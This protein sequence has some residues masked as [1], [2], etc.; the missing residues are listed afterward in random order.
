MA[1]APAAPGE[2][3]AY[4]KAKASDAI[5]NAAVFRAGLRDMARAEADAQA[6]LEVWPDGPDA[7]RL[8]LSLADLYA[9]RGQPQKELAQL[10]EYQ[11]RYAKEPDDWLAVQDR[12]ARIHE[13][14]GNGPQA[15]RLYD[16]GL[17][18]YRQH[19]AQVKDRGLALAAQAEYLA[20]EP[21]FAAYDKITLDV[22]PRYLK[23]QL[24]VKAR[25]LAQ[26]EADYGKVVKMKQAEPAICAL[27]RIGLGYSHFAVA[28]YRNPI[29]KEVKA[30][31]KGA[32]E[33]Y[34]A[35]L[36][37]VGEPLEKKAAEGYQLAVDAS[38]DYGVSNAC[39]K[40]AAAAL[41]KARPDEAAPTAAAAAQEVL[42]PLAALQASDPPVGY[43]LLGGVQ[44]Q[45]APRPAAARPE[46]VLPTLR[47][48]PAAKGT[49]K[50]SAAINDPQRRALDPD[51][52]V[53]SRKKKGTDDE[54]LLP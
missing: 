17:D 6:Y 27:H 1:P 18:Y 52:P 14:A 48:R 40:E 24:Q 46:V 35:Q 13:K 49:E 29:P 47:A 20:L 32:V 19:A 50:E 16:A 26:L 5:I 34:R 36:A 30:M 51:Q 23:A 21:A 15:R 12:M 42:P 37:Q 31:G 11:R 7:P 38:R 4:E 43:G 44:P 2:A 9:R 41:K 54:D 25:K 22:T 39:S 33:E 53:P 8:F 10:E 28:L 45:A 3:Q